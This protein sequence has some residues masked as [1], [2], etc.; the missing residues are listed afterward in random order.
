[1]LTQFTDAHMRHQGR[2]VICK[3]RQGNSPSIFIGVRVIVYL[4]KIYITLYPA[5]FC[6]TVFLS[7][8]SFY[9]PV[10]SFTKEFNPSLSKLTLIE[11]QWRLSKTWLNLISKGMIIFFKFLPVWL[12]CICLFSLVTHS[13]RILLNHP[14]NDHFHPHIF[15]TLFNT[16]HI[17]TH[18]MLL[19]TLNVNIM[20]LKLL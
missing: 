18:V 19:K 11:F 7:F 2:W 10:A 1:M 13:C 12:K 3:V 8:V 20:L 14:W 15:T 6:K 4:S 9:I 5:L 16:K 17:L